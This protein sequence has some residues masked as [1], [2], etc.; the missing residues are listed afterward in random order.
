M[1]GLAELDS[2]PVG[3]ASPESLTDSDCAFLLPS[4]SPGIS[5]PSKR[6]S[7]LAS[8]ATESDFLEGDATGLTPSC[9]LALIL[10]VVM[11]V[12]VTVVEPAVATSRETRRTKL[13][14]R[15]ESL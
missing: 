15:V 1:L 4:P 6:S 8:S 14:I 3:F 11:C 13:H 2:G 12:L 7:N 5:S 9:S 10:V